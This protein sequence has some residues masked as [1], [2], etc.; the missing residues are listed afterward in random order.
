M[1]TMF[2]NK[3]RPILLID[4]RWCRAKEWAFDQGID[5]FGVL[6][7]D[8]KRL[9]PMVMDVRVRFSGRRLYRVTSVF[10]GWHSLRYSQG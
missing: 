1:A 6:E 8:G 2:H 3:K 10:P 9:T 7:V 5:S 4:G